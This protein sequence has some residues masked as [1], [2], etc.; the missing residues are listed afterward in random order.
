MKGFLQMISIDGRIRRIAFLIRS[1]G[2][3]PRLSKST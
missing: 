3:R 2:S 1:G